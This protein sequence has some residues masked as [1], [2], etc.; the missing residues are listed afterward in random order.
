MLV[1]RRWDFSGIAGRRV[2]GIVGTGGASAALGTGIDARAGNASRNV[3]SD[4]EPELPLRARSGRP[5]PALP[6]DATDSDLLT[7]LFVCTSATEMGVVGLDRN[8]APAAAEAR[9]AFEAR[10]FRKA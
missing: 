8:A 3:L 5:D 6:L 1:V 9:E 2:F 7:V 10:F 4:M